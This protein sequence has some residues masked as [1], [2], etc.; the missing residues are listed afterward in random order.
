MKNK[1]IGIFELTFC[2]LAGMSLAVGLVVRVVLL[3]LV[4]SEVAFGFA[5]LLKIFLLGAVNDLAISVLSFVFM[6]LYLSQLSERKYKKPT[7]YIIFGLCVAGLVYV[8]F[9]NTIFHE[10][11]SVVPDIVIGLLLYVTVSFG[12][13]LF[14]PSIRARWSRVVYYIL[15]AIYMATVLFNGIGAYFFW[16]EFGV[17]YNFI[18][19]DYLIYTNEVVG[20]IMESYPIIPLLTALFITAGLLTWLFNSYQLA[21]TSYQNSSVIA[22]LT[23]NP[24][25][26]KRKVVVAGVYVAAFFASCGVLKFNENFQKS[27]N[28]YANELQANSV[29]KFYTAFMN[30]ELSFYDFYITLPEEEAAAIVNGIYG[31]QGADNRQNITS[32]LPASKKNIVLIMVESLSASFLARYGNTENIT[33]NLN[34]LIDKGLSFD[35]LF[36]TGTRT[37]RGLE[38]IT[39][40]LPPS[41]GESIVKQP[42]NANLFSTGSVLREQ[43]YTV[44][45]F[46]GGDGYFDNMKTF[47]SGNGYEVIDKPQFEKSEITF[48]NIWGVCDEDLL[49]KVTH[50]LRKDHEAGKPFFAHIMTTSNHRPYTY[51]EGKID[52]PTNKSRAGGVKYTDY[53]IGKFID[54][55]QKE[56]WFDNTVFVIIADHCASS[57]GATEIPLDKYQ[58]PCIIYAPGFVA[59]KREARLVSQIDIMPTILGLLNMSYTSK[60]YGRDIYTPDYQERAVV[61]TYQNLGYFEPEQLT[62]LSPVRRVEQFKIVRDGFKFDLPAVETVDSV[63]VKTAVALYQIG[64]KH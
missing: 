32:A 63:A 11:G 40:C 37:V 33:P 35:N 17:R 58:I 20:N 54:D 3:F 44:Q 50:E 52:I 61:A 5:N 26:W 12:L 39:L 16:D 1:N 27:D 51:P 23:R 7:G 25:T 13:R 59:P 57:A 21:V 49:N 55:A 45:F 19:V 15:F 18:A 62:I 42:N 9:F 60:F 4:P 30:S 64:T 34:K 56:A 28:V 36:A 29:Y 14:I 46:Y 38:A 41:S 6:W 53:A 22:G 2:K 47:F 31:S 48:S 43:G 24:L 10:Y 8:S